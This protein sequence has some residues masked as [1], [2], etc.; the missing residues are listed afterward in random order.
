LALGEEF[1]ISNAIAVG[2]L[3]KL[4]HNSVQVIKAKTLDYD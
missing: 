3:P 1:K 4:S 2:E